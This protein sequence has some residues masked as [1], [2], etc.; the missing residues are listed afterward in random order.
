MVAYFRQV[1]RIDLHRPNI[2]S[3]IF[4][5]R[6]NVPTFSAL[7]IKKSVKT[8]SASIPKKT[9]GIGNALRVDLN[10]N[11]NRFHIVYWWY[12]HEIISAGI[13]FWIFSH[14]VVKNFC[15]RG[16]FFPLKRIRQIFFA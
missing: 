12:K 1:G 16:N 10:R 2:I 15:Y 6:L 11:G 3:A 4:L 9:G 5:L 13:T 8:N 7:I 14:I